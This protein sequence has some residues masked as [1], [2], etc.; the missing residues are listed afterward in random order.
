MQRRSFACMLAGL[1]IVSP[2]VAAIDYG[3]W[4][5]HKIVVVAILTVA[6]AG[7]MIL[8]DEITTVRG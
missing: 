5:P 1:M 7:V 6:I 4:H 3:D 8:Y 2:V